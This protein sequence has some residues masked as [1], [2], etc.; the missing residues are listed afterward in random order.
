M[1]QFNEGGTFSNI[2]SKDK[3]KELEKVTKNG[4]DYYKFSY[5]RDVREWDGE[6]VTDIPALPDYSKVYQEV[7][8]EDDKG[9]IATN[10]ISEIQK[11]EDGYNVEEQILD[12]GTIR[13]NL[14][15]V[16]SGQASRIMAGSDQELQAFLNFGIEKGGMTIKEFN[17]T[18][19]NRD[20]RLNYIQNSLIDDSINKKFSIEFGSDRKATPDDVKR[21]KAYNPSS[22]VKVG[23]DIR[24]KR[25]KQDIIEP[26]KGDKPTEGTI[27][28]KIAKETAETVL[29][30]MLESPK[31]YFK[32]RRIN[33]K[34]VSDVRIVP[35]TVG[36]GG[37]KEG[38]TL[39]IGYESGTSTTGG[40]RTIFTDEMTF[41]LDD[42]VR[43][44]TLIDM[45]PR[46]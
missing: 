27:K 7:N 10:L 25:I 35:S 40:E 28:R 19:P 2:V 33:G 23:D 32:D 13:K 31:S 24:F 41:D 5:K 11:T 36:E 16:M 22:T 30:D 34:K 1:E 38:R 39:E 3:Q 42:P 4:K 8:I 26:D 17:K 45:L 46:S 9:S 12:I 14:E 44:R 20:D 43:V 37:E 15:T 29:N 21:I 18:Y 6:L